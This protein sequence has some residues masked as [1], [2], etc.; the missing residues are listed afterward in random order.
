[1]IDNTNIR[2]FLL[3]IKTLPVIMIIIRGFTTIRTFLTSRTCRT[4]LI[5]FRFLSQS[6][7]RKFEF[8]GLRIY[9]YKF[10]LNLITFLISGLFY[11]LITFPI[12]L[13]N[14]EQTILT[15]KEF[16]KQSVRHY[17]TNLTF[18]YFTYLR[19]SNNTT[20]LIKC[21]F[22]ACAVICGNLYSSYTIYLFN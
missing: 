22:N 17:A 12:Y 8:S 19:N 7:L 10:N 2:R 20:N 4:F 1:M 21:S 9:F 14:M 5:T 13:G 16:D 18:I 11:C 15:R 6:T 3:F